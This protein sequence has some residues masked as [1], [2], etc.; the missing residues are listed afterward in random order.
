MA[1]AAAAA[2]ANKGAQASGSDPGKPG[3]PPDFANRL[4]TKIVVINERELD[5][6][7][8]ASRTAH[9]IIRNLSSPEMQP[10]F[11]E[12]MNHLILGEE[13]AKFAA[14]AYASQKF[15][16]IISRYPTANAPTPQSIARISRVTRIFST[17][18]YLKL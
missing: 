7:K 13:T 12:A 10:L 1:Q 14:I 4:A 11:I 9:L 6:S 16:S 15:S 17:A 18:R 2:K 5:E 8:A 3:V